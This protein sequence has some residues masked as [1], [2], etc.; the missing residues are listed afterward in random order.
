MHS[1]L[2]A[3][4]ED[5]LR[6]TLHH[7]LS[8]TY[9]VTSCA[10][11]EE[12]LEFLRTLQ[13]DILVID[14]HLS[15][16]DG[17]GVL[18]MAADLLPP[19]VLATTTC[20]NNYAAKE[21]L[22]LGADYLMSVPCSIPILQKRLADMLEKI[23]PQQNADIKTTSTRILRSLDFQAGLDGYT[24][25]RASVSI[26][27]Q[28]RAQALNKEVYPIVAQLYGYPSGKAVERSIRN[29]ATKAWAGRNRQAWDE[30]FPGYTKCPSNKIL[31]ARLADLLE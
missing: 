6:Q 11:G 20:V 26:Y 24:Q 8:A 10:D 16:I 7:I 15:K 21:A 1:L 3:H 23:P 27:A 28:D 17:L 29:A 25:L 22:E 31:I 19:I 13:P 30:L 5:G 14:L 12:T 4:G 2:L 18:E 9:R